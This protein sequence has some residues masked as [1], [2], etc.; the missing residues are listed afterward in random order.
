MTYQEK[1]SVVSIITY[2]IF[3]GVY[4]LIVFNKFQ[5]GDFDHL[6]EMRFWATII[7]ISIPIQVAVKIVIEIVLAIVSEVASE[8]KGTEKD[9]LDIVD[10][11]DRII[12]LKTMR[13]EMVFFSLGF[14]AA[15]GSQM[16]DLSIHVFFII[17]VSVGFLSEIFGE[18]LKIHFYRNGV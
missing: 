9:H 3:M 8:I 12:E 18:S 15:L 11:R 2:I 17:I 14:M 1:K 10:E 7:L 5:N 16:F 6:S 13:A 4:A